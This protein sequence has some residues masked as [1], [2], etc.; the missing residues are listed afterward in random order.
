MGPWCCMLSR[1]RAC[2]PAETALIEVSSAKVASALVGVTH[3][4]TGE[5]ESV[6]K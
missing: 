1:S 5:V 6:A 3:M 2:H 4:E